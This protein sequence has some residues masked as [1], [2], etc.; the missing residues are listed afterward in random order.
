MGFH[1]WNSGGI[2]HGTANGD[3]FPPKSGY[4]LWMTRQSEIKRVVSPNEWVDFRMRGDEME[5][6]GIFRRGG[7]GVWSWRSETQDCGHIC[8]LWC[9][10]L[11]QPVCKAGGWG[12]VGGNVHWD[13]PEAQVLGKLA[14][15][16]LWVASEVWRAGKNLPS[17]VGTVFSPPQLPSAMLPRWSGSRDF[18][19]SEAGRSSGHPQEEIFFS[20]CYLCCCLLWGD[21][22]N[23]CDCSLSASFCLSVPVFV[24][25]CLCVCLSHVHTLNSGFSSQRNRK[26]TFSA[27]ETEN[28]VEAHWAN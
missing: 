18:Q 20:R 16:Q 25:L 5:L 24:S 28:L 21:C 1:N 14:S 17:A 22:D 7:W 19:R 9:Q 11:G 26:T 23:C 4:Q 13:D 8:E 27:S 15:R 3:F 6:I 10:S 2:S 12:R